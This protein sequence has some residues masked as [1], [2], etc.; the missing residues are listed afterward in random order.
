MSQNYNQGY[1]RKNKSKPKA[2][3]TNAM[4]W[5]KDAIHGVSPEGANTKRRKKQLKKSGA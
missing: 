3:K 1:Y 4:Q 5:W 2:Y